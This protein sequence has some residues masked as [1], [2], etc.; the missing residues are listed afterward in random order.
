MYIYVSVMKNNVFDNEL[1]NI[2]NIK[3][4]YIKAERNIVKALMKISED[5][6]VTQELKLFD[7]VCL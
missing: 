3:K 2:P 7:C 6:D 1:W 5:D 4:Q